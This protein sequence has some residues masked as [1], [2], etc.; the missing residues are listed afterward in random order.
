MRCRPRLNPTKGN[1]IRFRNSLVHYTQHTDE[2]I[3]SAHLCGF[4]EPER[5]ELGIDVEGVISSDTPQMHLG[6]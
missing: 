6:C 1:L 4:A 5:F 3:V 2:L